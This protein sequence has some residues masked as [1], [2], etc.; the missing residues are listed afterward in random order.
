MRHTI[1]S[2]YEHELNRAIE[3]AEKR[4]WSLVQTGREEKSYYSNKYHYSRRHA[5]ESKGVVP[6]GRWF[7]VME[8][9]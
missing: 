4:G 9:G 2:Y 7:A 3:D 6:Y 1:H 8:R 5:N